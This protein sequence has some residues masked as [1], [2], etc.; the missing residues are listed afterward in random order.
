[1]RMWEGAKSTGWRVMDGDKGKLKE[2]MWEA[3]KEM[4]LPHLSPR[5]DALVFG[6][7]RES[8]GKTVG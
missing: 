4:D 6:N 3:W 2:K 7:E 1:M 8:C 5:S